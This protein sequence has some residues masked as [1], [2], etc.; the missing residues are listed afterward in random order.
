MYV[1]GVSGGVD[2]MLLLDMMMKEEKELVVAHVNHGFRKESEEEYE[3]VKKIC[4][5]NHILFEG[6]SLGLTNDQEHYARE[7]RYQFYEKV[8]L[9]YDAEALYLGHHGDDLV[10][11]IIMNVGRGGLG[12]A[13]I[14]MALES[15]SLGELSYKIRRPL[16]TLTKEEIYEEAKKR[17]LEWMEDPTNQEKEKYLRN[18]VRH[19]ILPQIKE[20]FPNFHKDLLAVTE[21][22]KE[23][24][25]YLEKKT[26]EKIKQMSVMDNVYKIEKRWFQEE[27]SILV[28]KTMKK[29]MKMM[30]KEKTKNTIWKDVRE[31]VET[32]KLNTDFQKIKKNVWLVNDREYFYLLD[33]EM[34]EKLEQDK[35]ANVKKKILQNKKVPK[36]FRKSIII[37]EGKIY[38][39]LGNEY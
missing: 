1:L 39:L 10:E 2:S 32:K 13:L 37:T 27:Q 15:Q 23:I 6:V 25:E 29:M 14:G 20:V 35:K 30:T 18:K 8:I 16:L 38:D 22:K 11:T 33:D 28:K 19:Q 17:N 36:A 21:E 4:E 34:K 31:K 3:M 9:K 24:E 5:K 26:K 12:T 7:K